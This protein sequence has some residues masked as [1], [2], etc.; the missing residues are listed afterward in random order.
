M[1][2]PE[3]W[4]LGIVFL[5]DLRVAPADARLIFVSEKRLGFGTHGAS[6][7]AQRFSDALIHMFADHMDE[8]D[9]AAGHEEADWEQWSAYGDKAGSK[10]RRSQASLAIA[11]DGSR[12]LQ[13]NATKASWYALSSAHGMP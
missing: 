13:S 11:L 5:E 3:L 6:N 12:P 7:S 2:V 9:A 10:C 4:K 1:A 8:S